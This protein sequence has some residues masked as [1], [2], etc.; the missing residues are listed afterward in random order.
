[1]TTPGFAYDLLS[2]YSANLVSSWTLAKSTRPSAWRWMM[3]KKTSTQIQPGSVGRGEVQP[4]AG[5]GAQPGLDLGVLW[6]V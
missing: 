3:A 1:L 5:M 4:D 6:V 2:P